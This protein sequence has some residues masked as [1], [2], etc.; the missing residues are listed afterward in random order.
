MVVDIA[1]SPILHM[2]LGEFL[3]ELGPPPA[4]RPVTT[5][6]AKPG[7]QQFPRQR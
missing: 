4:L 6:A 5:T 3:P 7:H 1:G 2:L